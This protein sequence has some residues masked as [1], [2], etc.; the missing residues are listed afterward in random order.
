MFCVG[1]CGGPASEEFKGDKLVVV[2]MRGGGGGSLRIV[3]QD[4]NQES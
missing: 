3:I 2:R 4:E 1:V